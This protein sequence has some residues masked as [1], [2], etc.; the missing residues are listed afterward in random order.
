MATQI[1]AELGADVVKV[2]RPRTGDESRHWE[3]LLPGGESAYFFAVN[4]AKRSITLNLKSPRGQEIARSPRGQ[5]RR[6]GGE[7]PARR[8]GQA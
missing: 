7:L 3:P 4:R 8:D 5:S 1:L 2:E 6:R